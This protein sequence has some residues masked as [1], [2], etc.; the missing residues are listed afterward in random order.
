M[1][2]NEGMIQLSQFCKGKDWFFDI[3]TDACNNYV[4]YAKFM[5]QEML[6]NIPREM[7]GKRVLVH[8]AAAKLASKVQFTE[9]YSWRTLPAEPL[10]DVVQEEVVEE[11]S[12]Q[13]LQESLDYLEKQCSSNILQNIFYEIHDGRNAVT[14]LSGKF[15]DVHQVLFKLYNQYGFDQIYEE[16]DG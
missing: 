4:V 6:T 16:L 9:Q 7:A 2:F 12:I 14:N 15:P 1:D 8:F 10:E 5:N 3:G 13:Y 11:N